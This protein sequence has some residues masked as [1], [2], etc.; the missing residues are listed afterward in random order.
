LDAPL[1]SQPGS[2]NEP[3][4][5]KRVNAPSP[6]QDLS[7]E[8]E[9]AQTEQVVDTTDPSDVAVAA[10]V[11]AAEAARSATAARI[12][13]VLE[14]AQAAE[15][16]AVAEVVAAAKAEKV[17]KT[18][19]G[20][21]EVA[22]V[23]VA[24]G[25]GAFAGLGLQ[26][27]LLDALTKKGYTDP[28]PIQA[29]AIPVLLEGRDLVGQAQTGTGK[30]AAFALP[31]LQRIDSRVRMVQALILAPTREL[32]LQVTD[33]LQTYG[34]GIGKLRVLTV[35]GGAPIYR[36]LK[37]L[38]RGVQVVVG[39]PGRV[40]DCME[41]GA[42]DL[43]EVQCVVLDEAD[44]ML[45]MGFIDDVEWILSRTP[46]VRQTALFSATMPPEI[47]RVARKYLQ[48]P[49][50]IALQ[51]KTK[52]VA[53]T[54]QRCLIVQHRQKFDALARVLEAEKTEAV[55]IFAR[56][57]VGCNELAES[58][59]VRGFAASALHGDM[60]QPQRE[61]VVR[62]MKAGRVKIVVATDVAARGLDVDGV[63]HVINY[64]L[65]ME[66]EI[67]VH[68][69][70]RTG[71]AGREG[72][73]LIFVTPRERRGLQAIERFTGQVM[74]P[75]RLPTNADI[76][77]RR[78]T[79]LS[80][81]IASQLESHDL[82]PYKE[83]VE[84]ML[85]ERN[86]ELEPVTLAAAIARM[87]AG[88]KPLV[89]TEPEPDQPP[90]HAT[91]TSGGPGGGHRG[92]HGGPQREEE[93]M[94]RLFISIGQHAGMRPGTLVGA[95][96]N[97]AGIP[98]K[99]IGAI[100][101]REKATFFTLDAR[102]VDHVMQHMAKTMIRGRLAVIRHAKPERQQDRQGGWRDNRRSFKPQRRQRFGR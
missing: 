23:E 40:M 81:R 79:E 39:T 25:S 29:E 82:D 65:P 91:G 96:T 13:K 38:E 31:L 24:K 102:Y 6:A 11:D 75:V 72:V 85:E 84:K 2:Q 33:A 15:A 70:G 1:D 90:A 12:A 55:L 99:A 95:I 86:G 73:S 92:G 57:K 43:S 5:N 3:E 34:D 68:R 37:S 74:K 17:A 100:D 71:R 77:Q 36:Q 56:T 42:L 35:Y 94:V 59:R 52:T 28:T 54:E 49:V 41:R 50:H 14:E 67:Y 9:F 46:D 21:K 61:E 18:E 53:K 8:E 78:A 60:N 69:I 22:P 87:A 80:A 97:E 45:R 89:L 32:A 98:A 27:E 30:T 51:S 63:T 26:A 4:A 7:L 16:A 48:N 83:L 20:A 93:G 66:P 10:A 76:A 58:L 64:D 62:L 47:K 88:E 44:E 101:I 19:K